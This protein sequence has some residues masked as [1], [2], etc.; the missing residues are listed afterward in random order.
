[1]AMHKICFMTNGFSEVEGIDFNER[2]FLI[3]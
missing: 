3:A 1:M 2:F